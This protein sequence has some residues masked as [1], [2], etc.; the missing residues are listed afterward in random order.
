MPSTVL[1][2]EDTNINEKQPLPSRSW[3]LRTRNREEKH[4][5]Q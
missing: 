3:C 5:N 2:P 4:M 1:G